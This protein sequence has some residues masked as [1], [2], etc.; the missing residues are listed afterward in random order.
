MIRELNDDGSYQPIGF[1]YS[2]ER[3]LG[4]SADLRG[5]PHGRDNMPH[6]SPLRATTLRTTT[7]MKRNMSVWM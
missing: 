6:S 5:N 7:N 1:R 2:N 3:I 4:S